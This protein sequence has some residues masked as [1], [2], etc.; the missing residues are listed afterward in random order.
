MHNNCASTVLNDKTKDATRQFRAHAQQ[1][2]HK[3]LDT[4]IDK[5]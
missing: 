3:Y 2:R 1:L 4:N 5:M